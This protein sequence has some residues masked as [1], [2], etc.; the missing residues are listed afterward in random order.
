MYLC[1]RN[2]S[3]K[4]ITFLKDVIKRKIQF[5]VILKTQILTFSE[6]SSQWGILQDLYFN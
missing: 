6:F 2:S 4:L 3:E 1:L 5:Q